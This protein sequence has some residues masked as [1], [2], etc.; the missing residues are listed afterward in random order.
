M[1]N[2]IEM[3]ELRDRMNAIDQRIWKAFAMKKVVGVSAKTISEALH[4]SV[5]RVYQLI[6]QAEEIIRQ[7]REEE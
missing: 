3:E 7:H 4:V 1:L 5:P 2:K 6:N